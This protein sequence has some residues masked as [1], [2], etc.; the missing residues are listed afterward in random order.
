MN[1]EIL[2]VI[3]TVSNEK[4][5]SKAVIVDAIQHALASSVKKK[6]LSSR[7]SSI[8]LPTRPVTPIIANFII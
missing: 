8:S 2:M 7:T 5:V 1:K 4:N 3:D 6:S